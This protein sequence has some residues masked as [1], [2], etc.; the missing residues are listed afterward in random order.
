MVEIVPWRV[1]VATIGVIDL[2]AALVF[3]LLLPPSRNFER[4]A[5]LGARYHLNAWAAH[6]RHP[7]L[8]FLFALSFL[9][10]GA[11]VTVYNYVAFR[12][13]APPYQLSQTAVG[14]I[15]SAYVFGILGSSLSGALADRVG[16]APVLI[17]G[18]TIFVSGLLLTLSHALSAIIGG[19]AV[20]TLGFFVSHSVASGWVGRMA[21]Q[22]RGHAAS[23]YLLGYY[24]GS[25]VLGALGGWFWEQGGWPVL[26]EYTGALLSVAFVIALHL[27]SQPSGRPVRA[28][29]R[30]P[31]DPPA[32]AP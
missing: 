12:L 27:R 25:S 23:L 32:L 10:M 29:P 4:R 11:F 6:L 3:L 26:V 31:P 14:L 19:I 18:L 22:A 13:L 30:A 15:F 16:R 9:S 17:A 1:A 2:I 24:V 7:G 5:G 28:A 21:E 20:L 8:P